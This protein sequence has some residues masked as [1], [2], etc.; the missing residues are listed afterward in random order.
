MVASDH[1]PIVKTIEDKVIKYRRF[2]RFD[3]RWIGEDG[4]MESIRRGWNI[5]RGRARAGIVD[6]IHS[7]RHEISAWRKLNPPYGKDKIDSLQRALEEIQ[8]DFTKFNEEVLE[9]SR[10]LQEAYRDEEQYW[11]QK[12]R[13]NWH[14]L[15]D[16]N[17]KFYHTLTKQRRIQNR[18]IGLHNEEGNW[19]N[20][21]QDVEGVAERYFTDVFSTSSPANPEVFLE[22]VLTLVTDAQN[23]RLMAMATEKRLGPL[24]L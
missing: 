10:K 3:K 5:N 20:S 8:N 16:R 12:S 9:V 24:Y 21:E 17:T 22:K 23:L 2:F 15:G 19:V 7:C 1:R 4:L 11:E 13:T 18:I 14:V 6:K